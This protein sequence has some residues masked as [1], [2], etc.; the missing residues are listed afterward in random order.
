MRGTP[1]VDWIRNMPEEDLVL[2]FLWAQDGFDEPSEPMAKAIKFG[3]EAPERLPLLGSVVFFVLGAGL[4]LACLG[5]FLWA[6][7]SASHSIKDSS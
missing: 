7:R 2:P 4:L 5:Y 1:N 3:L 6:R